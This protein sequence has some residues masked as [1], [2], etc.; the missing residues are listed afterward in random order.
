MEILINSMRI[1]NFYTY[2]WE[3]K[4]MIWI[5]FIIIYNVSFAQNN[6]SLYKKYNTGLIYRY[7]SSIMKGGE[8]ITFQELSKEFSMSDLGLDQY[9]MAKKKNTISR[10]FSF[11]SL[12]AGIAAVS[13]VRSNRNLAFV[14]LG[15][16]YATLMGS[17]YYR[18]SSRQHLDRAI[19]IRNKDYLFPGR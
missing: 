16:Q 3:K 10:I 2:Y 6:D 1:N 7:G 14:F 19:F 4:I 8:K 17:G 5:L 11:A 15:G 12:A 9:K 18:H 13:V